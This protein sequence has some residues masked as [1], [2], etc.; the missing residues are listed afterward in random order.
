[1][2]SIVVLSFCI[3]HFLTE[4]VYFQLGCIVAIL[5]SLLIEIETCLLVYLVCLYIACFIM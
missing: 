4:D 1:M 3:L 2:N 5:R